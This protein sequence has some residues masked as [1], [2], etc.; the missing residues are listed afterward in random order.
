MFLSS[1]RRDHRG[2]TLIELLVVIAIIAILAAIL[3]PVFAK[4]REKARQASCASNEKQLALGML[5]YN[6]DNDE[7]FPTGGARIGRGWAS[8]IYPYTKSAGV[9]KCPDDST[10]AAKNLDGTGETDVP[11]SYALNVDISNPRGGSIPGGT[12]AGL[13][14]PASTVMF[15]EVQGSQVDVTNPANDDPNLPGG[16]DAGQGAAPHASPVGN[17]GDCCDGWL[18]W[19][20]GAKYATGNPG[21]NPPTMG[22]PA[23]ANQGAYVQNGQYSVHT[24]GGNFALADG[25]VKYLRPTQVSP[26][27]NAGNSTQ[28]Q[29]ANGNQNACGTGN[30]GSGPFAATFSGI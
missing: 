27:N 21:G 14:A 2:F 1:R 10:Q 17:G 7:L 20:S 22:N 28:A 8:R 4:A 18:Y 23:R 12:L 16:G 11:V 29:D 15:T 19:V 26:G 5:Q 25:H 3:F 9:Y 13:V 24:S 30:M 6:Q